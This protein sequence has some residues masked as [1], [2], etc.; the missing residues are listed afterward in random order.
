MWNQARTPTATI[1]YEKGYEADRDFAT[2]WLSRADDL[3]KDKYRVTA[4]GYQV[5]FYLYPE[6]NENAGVGLARTVTSGPIAVIHYLAPAAMTW[7]S[8]NRTT[9]LRFPFDENFHAKVIISEYIALAHVA[10]QDSRTQRGGWRYYMAPSWV[11]Q[12]LQEYDAIFHSTEFNRTVVARR[13]REFGTVNQG[14]FGC[15]QDG[16]PVIS[17]V[18]NG[19]ALFM[20]YLADRYGE[21]IHRRLLVNASAVF[22]QALMQETTSADAE[23]LFEDFRNWLKSP[24]P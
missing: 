21:D 20:W 17:D 2:T 14:W 1:F 9:S 24:P 15:C 22:A 16:V 10:V 8:T 5:S 12:G 13:L 4:T 7:K 3:M 11:S 23:G 6:P 18:Y 19:G